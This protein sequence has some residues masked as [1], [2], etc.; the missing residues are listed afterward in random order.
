M[1][2]YQDNKTPEQLHQE[3]RDDMD[4]PYD[5]ALGDI[6]C[7]LAETGD[8]HSTEQNRVHADRRF[9]AIQVRQMK[10]MDEMAKSMRGLTIASIVIA[11]ISLLVAIFTYVS[12]TGGC[13]G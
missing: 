12:A 1:A 13:A 7:E 11:V 2:T 9:F 4:K 10:A 3:A 6:Y 5:H 8:G